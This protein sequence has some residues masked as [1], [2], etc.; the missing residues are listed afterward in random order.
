MDKTEIIDRIGYFRVRAKLTQKALSFA[1]EMNPNYINRLES[2]R[3]FLPSLEVLLKIIEACGGSAEEFFYGDIAVYKRDR[4]LI[5]KLNALS[6]EQIET[7]LKYDA[8]LMAILTRLGKIGE[9]IVSGG[10]GA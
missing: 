8:E 2:K 9:K 10:S 5:E 3:D 7:V 6:V 1:I 4:G